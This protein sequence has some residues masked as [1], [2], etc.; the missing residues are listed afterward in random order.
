V[1]GCT[2]IGNRAT[3]LAFG[4][5]VANE[6]GSTTLRDCVFVGNEADRGGGL[7]NR[8]GHST[9]SNCVFSKHSASDGRAVACDS[10]GEPSS[11]DMTNCILWDGGRETWK[12]GSSTIGVTYSDVQG[13]YLGEGCVD[14][15][16]DFIRIPHP[17]L[18]G[19][20][21]TADDDPG[22]L[23]LLPGSP[24]IN[25]G[26]PN[27]IPEPGETDLDGHARVLCD[28][29]DMGAYEFGIGDYDCDSLVD[30]DDFSDCFSCITGPAG[31][32]YAEGC[33]ACDFDYDLDVDLFDFTGF[34][35]AFTLE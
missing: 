20:W 31:D 26:D 34:Q 24:C 33:E 4:G 30:L 15:D 32:P 17:G 5:G 6:Q 13:G 14:S 19:V 35:A 2:F 10:T 22:D 11:L 8:D 18:D 27:F 25:A 16:P 29:V 7:Y 23:R 12:G 21:G 1:V 9:L 3:E 28:R